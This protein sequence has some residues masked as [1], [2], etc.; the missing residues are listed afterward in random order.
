MAG[1]GQLVLTAS[2]AGIKP[3]AGAAVYGMSKAAVIHLAEVAAL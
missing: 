1:I 2:V 3:I